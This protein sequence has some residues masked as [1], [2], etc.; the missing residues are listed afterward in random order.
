MIDH[1]LPGASTRALFKSAVDGEAKGVF[2]GKV[3]RAS[4]TRRRPTPR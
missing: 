2:Q 1:A 3:D 4:A